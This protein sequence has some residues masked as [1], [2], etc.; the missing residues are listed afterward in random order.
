MNTKILVAII[1]CLL[2]A[3]QVI[4]SAPVNSLQN[5]SVMKGYVVIGRNVVLLPE[6]LQIGDRIDFFNVRGR[7]VFEQYV[8]SGYL[9]ANIS[10]VPKGNYTVV[11]YRNGK[12]IASQNTPII[13]IRGR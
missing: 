8:G 13:G 2:I 1:L 3:G 9:A 4:A 10:K 11:V 6:R 7:K 12:R 5:Q